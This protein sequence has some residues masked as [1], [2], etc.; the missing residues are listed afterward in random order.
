MKPFPPLAIIASLSVSSA[1]AATLASYS[2]TGGLLTP[3]TVAP[4]MGAGSVGLDLGANPPSTPSSLTTNVF[5]GTFSNEPVI[6]GNH[7][8]KQTTQSDAKS[9]TITMTAD[10]GYEFSI[11]NVSFLGLATAAGP[12]AIGFAIGSTNVFAT[13]VAASMITVVDQSVVG[14]NNLTSATIHI[15]GWDD[16]SRSTTGAGGFRLDDVLISGNVRSINPIPEPGSMLAL[17]F[18]IGGGALIRSRRSASVA[19]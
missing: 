17:A 8:W 19:C 7:G 1:M 9:F 15:Q 10:L 6:Q 2:F 4:N 14:Q 13:S 11:N 18:L 12:S 5:T 3:T 16:G